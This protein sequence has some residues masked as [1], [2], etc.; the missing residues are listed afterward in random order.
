MNFEF[1]LHNLFCLKLAIHAYEV[2]IDKRKGSLLK[3]A[4]KRKVLHNK[5]TLKCL[6]LKL[7]VVLT[8]WFC[9]FGN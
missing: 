6:I 9:Y 2:K 1:S 5:Y 7:H 8:L 4:H 3:K